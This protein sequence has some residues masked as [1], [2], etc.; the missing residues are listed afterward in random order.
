MRSE[1][2][3]MGGVEGGGMRVRE[4]GFSGLHVSKQAGLEGG[5]TEGRKDVKY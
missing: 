2:E 4:E 1:V 3:W 5:R